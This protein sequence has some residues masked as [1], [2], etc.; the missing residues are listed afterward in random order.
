V[1]ADGRRVAVITG[2]SRGIGRAIALGLAEDGIDIAITY[3]REREAA[4]ETVA[5]VEAL[6]SRARAYPATLGPPEVA[7]TLIDAVL[8]DFEHIDIL[9][10]NAGV[11]SRGL[12]VTETDHAE[13]ERVIGT[14]ALAA[15]QLCRWVLPSMRLRPRG[16]IIMISSI[17]TRLL[18]AG[19]AP[20][21]MAKAA[22]EALAMT[23]AKEEREHGVRVNVVAPGLVDT[24]MGRR[25]VR[26]TQGVEDIRQLDAG[27]PFGRVCTP[28]D[29]ASAVR[30]LVS[31]RCAYVTGQRIAVDGG[32][33]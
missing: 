14:H 10:S 16:D 21:A 33:S 7:Q 32:A 4:D 25:L 13:L 18:A 1:T 3:R 15:H 23:L 29:I 24:E 8:Q 17:A 19:G 22:L 27:S 28:D 12:P 30:F 31:D 20:Y 2:G 5:R 26:A 6:G 9:V 11:A